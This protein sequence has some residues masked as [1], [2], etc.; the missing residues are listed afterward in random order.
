MM[1]NP[2]P[3]GRRHAGH[4]ATEAPS[5]RAGLERSPSATEGGGTA[6]PAWD[7][8]QFGSLVANVPGA[9]YRCV[10]GAWDLVFMSA[11]VEN[12]CGYPAADFL[13]DAPARTRASVIHPEDRDLVAS[14]VD[15][16][17][18]RR[19]PF[20]I[21]Y[22]IVHANGELRRA[23]ER[24]RGVFDANGRL[25]FVDGVIF[26]HTEQERADQQHRLLF[27]RNPQPMLVYDR[28]TLRDRRRQRR[29]G[30]Q[31][32]LHARGVPR[33]DDPGPDA[34]RGRRRAARVPRHATRRR[35][36]RA[37][38]RSSAYPWRHR[39]KDG[40]IIDVEVT[41]DDL[42]LDGRECRIALCQD[43]TER[44]RAAP[45]SRSRATRRSRRR[46]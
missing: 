9:V 39:R 21:D 35:A 19:L 27:E 20:M 17:I 44:N 4:R 15:E 40:T 8:R 12:I 45:S 23:W 1:S 14:T 25:Q 29:A 37:R 36:S 43:V 41:S 28:E 3:P 16:A 46:T 24:G 13:G 5:S 31:L 42:V 30:R 38:G 11:E 7:E 6:G 22:R 34:A 18:A 33:D 26:D 10:G 32:R 2:K